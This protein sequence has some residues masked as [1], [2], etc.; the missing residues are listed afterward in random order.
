MCKDQTIADLRE[1]NITAES[2]S[3][4]ARNCGQL[5]TL[6]LPAGCSEE[7]LQGLGVLTFLEHLIV[8]APGGTGEWLATLPVTLQSLDISG[9]LKRCKI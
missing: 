6:K 5:E 7:T 4:L 3:E 1:F 8:P 2:L 9:K